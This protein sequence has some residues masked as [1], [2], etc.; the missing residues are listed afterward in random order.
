MF[1]PHSVFLT[2]NIG[3]LNETS[4]VI[5]LA[6]RSNAYLRGVLE[7]FLVQVNGL[8]FLKDFYVLDIED[9]GSPM[10][11]PFLLGRLFMTTTHKKID[12]Y[13]VV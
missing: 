4:V 5:Q 3:E 9:D 2:L 6:D 13:M 11:V 12:V 8:V 7:D 1:M 10:P